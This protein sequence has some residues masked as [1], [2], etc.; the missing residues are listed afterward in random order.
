MKKVVTLLSGQPLEIGVATHREARNVYAIIT[1]ELAKQNFDPKAEL[2]I[3]FVKNIALEISSSEELETSLAPIFS[4]SLYGKEK[5]R[6]VEGFFDDVSHR[7]D[8]L[9][10]M[11]QV[12]LETIRPFVK[13]LYGKYSHIFQTVG[14][15]LE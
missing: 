9:E 13:N 3:N 5:D 7:E 15:N 2:D 14:L 4:K 8:F 6:I 12:T 10:I 11:Y 1:K